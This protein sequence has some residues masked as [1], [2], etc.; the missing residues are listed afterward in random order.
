MDLP[1]FENDEGRNVRVCHKQADDFRFV[2]AWW[3]VDP[4]RTVS[5]TAETTPEEFRAQTFSGKKWVPFAKGG[6]Y[7]P[8]YAPVSW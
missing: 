1:P 2:R 3:E 7:S 4:A 5:G 6:E 8:Y